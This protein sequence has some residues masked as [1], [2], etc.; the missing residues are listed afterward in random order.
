MIIDIIIVVV[1]LLAIVLGA[2][3]GLITQICYLI[4]LIATIHIAPNVATQIGELITDNEASAYAVGFGV[5]LLGAAILVWLIAPIL[6][7]LLFWEFLR[8]INS[9]LGAVV[10]L[11][12]TALLLSLLSTTI[13]TA[14]LGEIDRDK[15][16]KL[17]Y[18]CETEEELEEEFNKILNKDVSMRD[19][20]EPRFISYETLDASRLFS[21]LVWVGDNIYPN[22]DSVRGDI[23]NNLK[24]YAAES[25][26]QRAINND[27]T[28]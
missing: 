3:Q 14:N 7:R 2:R 23:A 4:A 20:F 5:M 12:T 26:T 21:K 9:L 22:I 11:A 10:A 15:M 16:G 28:E 1:L 6:K 19:Y 8:K 24:Q 18:N 27:I 17:I 25:I 13:N